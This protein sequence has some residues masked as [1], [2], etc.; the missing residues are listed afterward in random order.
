[1]KIGMTSTRFNTQG[2]IFRYAYELAHRLSLDYDMHVITGKNEDGKSKITF[3]NAPTLFS[4]ISSRVISN[5]LSSTVVGHRLKAKGIIDLVHGNG[6]EYIRPDVYTAH[7]VHKAAVDISKKKRGWKYSLLKT[8]EPRT[9][10]VLGIEKANYTSLHN[11]EV[12]AISNT[13]KEDIIKYYGVNPDKIHV[14]YNGVD[15]NEFKPIDDIRRGILRRNIGFLSDDIVAVFCG[16]EFKRKGLMQIIE[17]L[18][19]LS[20]KV[21]LLVLGS[22]DKRDFVKRAIELGVQDRI[23][24]VG[25]V[26]NPVE[27]YQAS[28]L[29][30]FP[31]SYEP[32]GLVITEAMA[33]GLPVVTSKCAGA[34]ELIKD[35]SDGMLLNNPYDV[36]EIIDSVG[37][38][39]D[40]DLLNKMGGNARESILTYNWD[41][42]AKDTLKVYKEVL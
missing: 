8:F 39:V 9:N 25:H 5:T 22:A 24:F 35:G 4:T 30:I 12:I 15:I 34:S 10:V 2:G 29:M 18:P 20:K 38:I 23:K 3:H 31:T 36:Q 6:A 7:S 14:I 42:T 37:Y 40:N 27:Y 16:W 28:D 32:F 21:K 19:S 41:A 1:M 26:I 17:A 13:V 33:C 11:R